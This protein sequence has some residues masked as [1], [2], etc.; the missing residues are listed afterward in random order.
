MTFKE[1]T[2]PYLD[3]FGEP[4]QTFELPLKDGLYRQLFW[5]TVDVVAE[6]TAPKDNTE[7]GWAL[8]FAI[9][10]DPLKSYQKND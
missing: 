8:S 4:D 5:Y 3:Q 10:L 1:I 6:F 7:A 9:S 2:E